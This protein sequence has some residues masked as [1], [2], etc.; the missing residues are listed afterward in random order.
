MNKKANFSKVKL[1][2]FDLDGT[3]F[4]SSGANYVSI[5]NALTKLGL[6]K[7]T[8][9]QVESLLGKPSPEFYQLILPGDKIG[10]WKSLQ[11]EVRDQYDSI[12][13]E[14]GKLFPG[15]K[16]TLAELKKR[17]YTLVLYSFSGVAYFDSTISSLGIREYFDHAE[18]TE[19]NGLTKIE[20]VAK[21]RKRFGDPGTAVVGDR[22]NDYEAAGANSALTVGILYG[23]GKNEPYQADITIR[24]FSEMLDIFKGA[25]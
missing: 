11:K 15:V 14:Y 13:K 1:L 17:N 22:L 9:E 25:G 24:K 19:E 21:I 8:R 4:N 12:I 7:I 3:L 23:Y 2:I 5:N 18:C 16:S 6:S 20:L 10:I